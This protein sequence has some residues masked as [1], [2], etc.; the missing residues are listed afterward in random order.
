MVKEEVNSV[1]EIALCRWLVYF[2]LTLSL[3]VSVAIVHLVILR[4]TLQHKY[5]Q[6]NAS[7]IIYTYQVVVQLNLSCQYCTNIQNW[8]K[9]N[10]L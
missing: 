5:V 10:V 8:A 7:H 9:V 2:P 3:V 6:V 1:R 4:I